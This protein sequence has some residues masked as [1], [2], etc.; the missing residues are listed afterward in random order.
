MKSVKKHFQ[1]LKT[2]QTWDPYCC[3][4]VAFDADV[5]IVVAPS[6]VVKSFAT[7]AVDMHYYLL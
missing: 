4:A 5:V 6:A 1:C 2:K 7:V 3:C